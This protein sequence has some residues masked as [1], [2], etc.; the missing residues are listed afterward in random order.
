MHKNLEKVIQELQDVKDKCEELRGAKQDAIRE[1]LT[2]QEQQRAELRIINN[3]LMEET[4][5]RECLERRI[6]ELRTEVCVFVFHIHKSANCIIL[7]NSWN[8]CKLKMRLN[9]GSV[10]DWKQKNWHSNVIIKKLELK[11]ETFKRGRNE[12]DDQ[13]QIQSLITE[14]YSKNWPTKIR[15]VRDPKAYCK[16]SAQ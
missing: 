15:F 2:L 10:N 1:L 6:G 16:V 3:S 11:Y 5:A 9:G 7:E 13:F 4:T 14:I 8:G 12:E